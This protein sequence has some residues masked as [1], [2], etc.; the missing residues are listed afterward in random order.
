M[1]QI[2]LATI[3]SVLFFSCSGNSGYDNKVESVQQHEQNNPKQFLTLKADYKKNLAGKF[4]LEGS[5]SNAAKL[6]N[7]KDVEI[8]VTYFSKTKS[9][10]EDNKIIIYENV[11]SGGQ[12]DFKQKLDTPEGTESLAFS[13]SGA[14]VQ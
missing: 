12:T 2:F 3:I 1:K 8:A 11:P 6:T 13:L 14:S 5:I 9:K 10:I 7:Y 4:I